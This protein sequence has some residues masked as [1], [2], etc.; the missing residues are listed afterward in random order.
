MDFTYNQEVSSQKGGFLH[1]L[2]VLEAVKI[3]NQNID[4]VNIY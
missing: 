1:A 2:E 4:E 3:S